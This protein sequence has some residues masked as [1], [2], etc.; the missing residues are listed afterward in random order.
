MVQEFSKSPVWQCWP[1]WVLGVTPKAK[2][3][4]IEKAANDI[5]AKL[6]F[7][8]EAASVFITPEGEKKRDEYL[9]REAKSKLQDSTDRLIAEFWYIDPSISIETNQV[10]DLNDRKKHLSAKEWRIYFGVKN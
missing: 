2:N 6:N 5:T 8:V 10:D 9:V 3:A 4:D 1:F 7:G